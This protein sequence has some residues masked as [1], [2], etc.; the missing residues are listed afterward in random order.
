MPFICSA[1]S[2]C[3]LRICQKSVGKT[4]I[5]SALAPSHFRTY[6]C[7]SPFLIFSLVLWVL[8]T[9]SPLCL[10]DT[11]RVVPSSQQ[12]MGSRVSRWHSH[13]HRRSISKAR[14]GGWGG[15]EGRSRAQHPTWWWVAETR[16][17]LQWDDLRFGG[18]GEQT[19]FDSLTIGLVVFMNK[20]MTSHENFD[21]KFNKLISKF[22]SFLIWI[23]FGSRRHIFSSQNFQPFHVKEMNAYPSFPVSVLFTRIISASLD[24]NEYSHNRRTD[25]TF[26]RFWDRGS[27]LSL[28]V[29]IPLIICVI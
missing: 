26:M 27:G 3:L 18:F 5:V 19:V 16:S 23:G 2:Q 9:A 11:F 4:K 24:F 15:V 14:G 25:V 20:I 29:L 8:P 22:E 17:L 6:N 28:F 13:S 10:F 7:K 12:A 1:E 21:P